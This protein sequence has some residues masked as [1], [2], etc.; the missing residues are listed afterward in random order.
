VTSRAARQRQLFRPQWA[1]S[2]AFALGA[3]GFVGAAQWNSSIARED[4]VTSAQRVLV[5]RAE[6]LQREQERLTAQIEDADAQLRALQESTTGSAAELA[7][8]QDQ[9]RAA[10]MAAGTVE[11]R[12]PGVV[13]EIADSL[14]D[15]PPGEGTQNYIVLADDL[16]DIV[17]ALWASGAE[18]IAITGGHRVGAP[19]VRLVSTSSIY[20]AGAAILVNG[21]A[22]APP[23]V[24]EA[25]G[26]DGLRDRF[27]A[28]P[29]FLARV[30]DRIAAYELQFATDVRAELTLPAFAGNTRLNWGAPIVQD[31]A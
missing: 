10:R 14:R 30:E 1:V 28:N 26:P 16:R 22:I 31:P 25:I 13:V 9:L 19:T 29:A 12:G 2:M 8:L 3:I 23:Y 24:I 6:N 27:L 21:V 7:Q 5:S 18:A 20:N 4:F 11:V 17:T 15:V